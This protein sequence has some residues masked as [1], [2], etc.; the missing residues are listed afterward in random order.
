[1]NFHYKFGFTFGNDMYNCLIQY[2][3]ELFCSNS[4]LAARMS[5]KGDPGPPGADGVQGEPGIGGSRV[6]LS[7]FSWQ[8]AD[9]SIYKCT[10]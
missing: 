7:F 2:I 5:F 3:V 1:M 6:S 8:L 10:C 4:L 9:Y